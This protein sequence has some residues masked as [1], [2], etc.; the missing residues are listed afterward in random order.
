M[1]LHFRDSQ[2]S[3]ISLRMPVNLLDI[4]YYFMHSRARFRLVVCFFRVR[5]IAIVRSWSR[6]KSEVVVLYS[7][8]D[9]RTS[10][11]MHSPLLDL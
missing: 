5:V 8:L 10:E 6:M 11:L 4:H 1:L 7:R 9:F 2:A 3:V